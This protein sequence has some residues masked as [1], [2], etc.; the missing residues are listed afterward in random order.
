MDVQTHSAPVYYDPAI[1]DR[2]HAGKSA[3]INFYVDK[4][5]Q[6][7]GPI[8][9]LCCG[10]G[11]IAIPL[12][13][14]G[15]SVTGLDTSETMLERGREKASSEG[16]RVEWIVGDATSFQLGRRF[17][18]ILAPANALQLLGVGNPLDS[19]FESVLSHLE[20]AGILILDVMNPS[21]SE[22]VAGRKSGGQYQDPN[23]GELIT[24][25]WLI[26]YDDAQQVAHR[27]CYFSSAQ[28]PNFATDQL[29]MRYY[30]PE[31]LNL[32]VRSA[33]FRIIEKLGGF[34]GRPFSHGCRQQIVIAA[35]S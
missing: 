19:F 4:A 14:T 15:M 8:L 29:D 30:Y 9:E 11:R 22:I 2:R 1:Y 6:V 33:G 32:L 10:T 3:D 35:P 17:R 13:R 23:T 7:G 5:T 24:V 31:E 12:A 26:R 18:L 16:V 20:D 21:L 27:T 25:E 28:R 34:D